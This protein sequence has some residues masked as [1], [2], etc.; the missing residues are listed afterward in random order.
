LSLD[1]VVMDFER[2]ELHP[3]NVPIIEDRGDTS[4]VHLSGLYWALLRMLRNALSDRPA[5]IERAI[6]ALSFPEAEQVPD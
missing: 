6:T 5:E 3:L 4:I 2:N 1:E